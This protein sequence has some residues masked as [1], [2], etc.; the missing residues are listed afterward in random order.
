MGLRPP[1]ERLHVAAV[2]PQ[3]LAAVSDGVSVLLH[4]QEAQRPAAAPQTTLVKKTTRG[5]GWK[6]RGWG[7]SPVGVGGHLGGV[8]FQ[9][10]AVLLDGLLVLSSLHQS[11]ALLLQSLSFFYVFVARS[12]RLNPSTLRNCLIKAASFS[13][14]RES[15]HLLCLSA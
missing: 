13:D 10:L 11:V 15:A 4:R 7:G 2:H 6:Q 8:V 1:V 12:C 9:A 14:K 5:R 3:S